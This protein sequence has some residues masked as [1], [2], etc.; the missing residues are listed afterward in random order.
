MATGRHAPSL[1]SPLQLEQRRF[2]PAGSPGS[3]DSTW[4]VPVC[5]SWGDDA[6]TH[7]QCNLLTKAADHF[8][9]NT[10]KGCPAWLFADANATGY[11][12][13][14]YDAALADKLIKHGLP[15]L[16]AD[17]SAA[18]LRNVQ[19][20]F[21]SGV[22]DPAQELAFVSEFSHSADPGLVRQA[23][24]TVRGLSDFVPADL[25]PNYARFIRSLYARR[26]RELGWQPKSGESQEVRLLRMNIVP[27]VA[28]YGEDPE[29]ASQAAS[30][31]REWLKDRRSLDPDMV[32]PV[33]AV[34]AWNGD[35]RF[36][37]LLVQEITKDKTQRERAWMIGALVCFRDPVIT[38][39]RLELIFGGGIDPRELQYTLIG[40]TPQT[41]EI[42]WQFV[43]QNF[44]R[45]NSTIPGAR[46]VPFGSY[47]PLSAGS[48]CDAAHQQQVESFF[49][50][51]IATLPGG[52][53]NLANTLERIRLC[54]ARAALIQ[55]AIV[56]LLRA[57][58]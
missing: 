9:L 4:A 15:H 18:A 30:L 19:L 27:L 42:V 24:E 31:A 3:T 57:I 50:P 47:L 20:M 13:V 56:S 46:G 35:R 25:S 54:S 8:E 14:S 40:I 26:A 38:R 10:P 51:R 11:Y 55:P 29:L 49:Q 17:E 37:D 44:D 23:A 45:I 6:G 43:E 52:A 48:F 5:I 7:H 12:A 39:A 32:T 1:V 34:A 22:G 33:L 41:R 28:A 36:Y 53:R 58:Q 2:L 21:S 16:Q